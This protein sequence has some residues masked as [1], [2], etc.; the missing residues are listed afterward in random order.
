MIKLVVTDLDGTFLNNQGSYDRE[1]FQ[2]VYA[3]MKQQGIAFA[4]CTGKQ[5]ERVENLFQDV[6]EGIWILGD[7]AARM[8]RDGQLVREFTIESELAQQAIR[9]ISA[10]DP[11]M[12]I[13]ACTSS[14]AYVHH[15][16]QP[17]M[18]D[19][20]KGS[21]Q[22]VIQVDDFAQI[23]T[24]F[25]K[26]TVYDPRERSAALREHIEQSLLGQIYIVDSEP[27]WLD[28]TELHTHKGETVRRLQEMLGV[29]MAET[30]TFGDGEN[31]VELMGVAEYSFA[32]RNAC[33]N[34]KQ[35]A[36]FVTQSNEENGVLHTISKM[37][38]LQEPSKNTV[39]P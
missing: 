20:V 7:S 5:C 15:S 4:A 36:Q 2:Q 39:T 22:Q 3:E 25:I 12:T 24:P 14:S 28:I 34:T 35:A 9:L 6:A 18:Y 38:A 37:I 21:Y 19:I 26:I 23:D 8:K 31:D 33:E 10:F 32:V 29:S 16:I 17:D 1:L 13:I 27:R 11:Q 30:M